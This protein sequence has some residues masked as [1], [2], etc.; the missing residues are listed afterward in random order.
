[1]VAAATAELSALGT[2]LE[3]GGSSNGLSVEESEFVID[4]VEKC[5]APSTKDADGLEMTLLTLK[6]GL[7]V[8]GW[9]H[10][11]ELQAQVCSKGISRATFLRARDSLKQEGLITRARKGDRWVWRLL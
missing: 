2:G 11:G 1:L 5:G 7:P 4:S 9:L 3:K 8:V 10:V 6:T